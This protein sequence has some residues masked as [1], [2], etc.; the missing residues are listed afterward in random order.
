MQNH[1]WFQFDIYPSNQSLNKQQ[2]CSPFLDIN[3]KLENTVFYLD[4]IL[5]YTGSH[6]YCYLW[7][8]ESTTSIGGW[9]KYDGMKNWKSKS[10]PIE[11]TQFLGYDCLAEIE[12]LDFDQLHGLGFS[13]YSNSFPK[14][15]QNISLIS[16]NFNK[17]YK[18]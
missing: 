9:Y 12:T 6:F 15:N 2:L 11:N 3:H 13:Q 8:V 18:S 10:F 7:I 17:D 5:M 4:T 16:S 1:F 14:L